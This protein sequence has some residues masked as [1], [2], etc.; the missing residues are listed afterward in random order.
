[1]E[2]GIPRTEQ[3]PDRKPVN[4]WGKYTT[5]PEGCR[6]KLPAALEFLTDRAGDVSSLNFRAVCVAGLDSYPLRGLNFSRASGR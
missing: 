6:P 4:R 1:M 5:Q 3:Q 2:T